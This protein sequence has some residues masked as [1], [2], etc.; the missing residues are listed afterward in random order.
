MIK[1][2]QTLTLAIAHTAASFTTY[3]EPKSNQEFHNQLNL[4]E[5]QQVLLK[6]FHQ[7][8]KSEKLAA[9]KVQ[10]DEDKATLSEFLSEA[11]VEL[12]L[13][14]TKEGKKGRHHGKNKGLRLLKHA[15]ELGLSEN[16]ISQIES[17]LELNKVKDGDKKQSKEERMAVK[18]QIMSVLTQEQIELIEQKR[19]G[20][21]HQK[22]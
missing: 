1:L 3:A 6:Q 7:Q 22:D 5:E 20:K 14:R 15:E 9:K 21:K 10:M 4:S 8:R 19:N 2:T 17:I 11:Q 13:N 18:E 16:Q 12:I